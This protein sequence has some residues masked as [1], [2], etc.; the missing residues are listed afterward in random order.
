MSIPSAPGAPPGP[1]LLEKLLT[2]IGYVLAVPLFPWAI[3]VIPEYQRAVVFRLGRL[4]GTRGPGLFFRLPIIDQAVIVDLRNTTADIA[5]QLAITSD[6][7]RVHVHASIDFRVA[8]PQAVVLKGPGFLGEPDHPRYLEVLGAWLAGR[9]GFIR[10]ISLLA[11]TSLP[12]VLR[13]WTLAD[14]NFHRERIAQR[15]QQVMDEATEPYGI[16]VTDVQIRNVEPAT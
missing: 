12:S 6:N 7:V 2:A 5:G 9:A 1:G 15:L 16:K 4:L 8:D 10:A 3:K 13:E 11:E 14:L